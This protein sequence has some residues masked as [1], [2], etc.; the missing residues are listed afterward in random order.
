M[1][2]FA[3][4]Y[5]YGKPLVRPEEVPKLPT[6]MRRLHQWYMEEAKKGTNWLILGIKDEISYMEMPRYILN[7][8][9]YFSYSIKTP[10][11]NL[12]SVPIVCKYFFL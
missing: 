6:K 2:L 12:S 5:Q 1:S 4:K 7:L 9:N 3:Y 10:S 8:K 11:I